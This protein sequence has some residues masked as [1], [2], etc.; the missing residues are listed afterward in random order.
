MGV[1]PD[2]CVAR[3]HFNAKT[4]RDIPISYDTNTTKDN[5][6][7]VDETAD[8][9]DTTVKFLQKIYFQS[10]KCACLYSKILYKDS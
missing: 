7:I 2:K 10:K 1:K 9:D 3:R 8:F 4:L 5:E 6:F